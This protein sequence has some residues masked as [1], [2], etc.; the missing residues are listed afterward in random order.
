MTRILYR[1][2]LLC[3]MT[4]VNAGCA[5]QPRPLNLTPEQQASFIQ[6]AT[7]QE[8]LTVSD[9][10]QALSKATY[11]PSIINKMTKPAEGK[12]YGDYRKLLLTQ[13]RIDLGKAFMKEHSF[14]FNEAKRKY[15]PRNDRIYFGY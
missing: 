1:L 8:K 15:S 11:Q 10:K 3:L 2:S 4:L 6:Q 12:S 9:V 14:A 7:S 13:K 5:E